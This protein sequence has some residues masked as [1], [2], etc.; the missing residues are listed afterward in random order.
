[1]HARCT[2]VLKTTKILAARDHMFLV[3]LRRRRR[4]GPVLKLMRLF[5]A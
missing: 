4:R 5:W 1:M 3:L 2:E